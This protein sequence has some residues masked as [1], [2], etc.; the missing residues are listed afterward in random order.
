MGSIYNLRS[1]PSEI[2]VVNG[3]DILVTKKMS[4]EELADLIISQTVK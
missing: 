3:K 4:N 2:L 1:M